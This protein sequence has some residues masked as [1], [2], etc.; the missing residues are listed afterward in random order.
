MLEVGITII[1][2]SQLIL[3]V[4]FCFILV[5]DFPYAWSD[6]TSWSYYLN[7]FIIVILG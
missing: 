1:Q 3:V 4:G 2:I 5:N 7:M 6:R